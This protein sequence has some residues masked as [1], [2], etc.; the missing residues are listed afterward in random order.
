[1]LSTEDNPTI[2]RLSDAKSDVR[3]LGFQRPSP[4]T[5]A[6]DTASVLRCILRTVA[7]ADAPPYT[8]VSY[9]WG[10]P[11]PTATVYIND[12]LMEVKAS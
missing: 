12:R 10:S 11:T 1:M 4:T 8:T 5:S 9:T 2:V 6:P 3:V 7:L